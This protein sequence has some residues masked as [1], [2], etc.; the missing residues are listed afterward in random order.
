MIRG[1]VFSYDSIFFLFCF[2]LLFLSFHSVNLNQDLEDFIII[3]KQYDLARIW[4][5]ENS[6]DKD[7]LTKDFCFFF[8]GKKA[9]FYSD[10]DKFF[11]DCNS[12]STTESN[13]VDI[14]YIDNLH[15]ERLTF[16]I[17]Y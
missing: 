17:Y 5:I 12:I 13:A 7:L 14:Y 4:L 3:Q 16:V 10:K 2:C 1:F 6:F 8:Y 9:Y 11:V 15:L